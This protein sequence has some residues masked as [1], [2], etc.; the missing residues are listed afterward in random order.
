M[1]RIIIL[2]STLALMASC[3]STRQIQTA[4]TK[5]DTVAAS[6]ATPVPAKVDTTQLIKT[7]LQKLGANRVQ[8]QTFTAKIDVDY[9]G[10]DGKKYDL[11]ANIRMY[12]DSAIW[13]SA[14]ATLL[15]IEVMRA[16]ITKDSI[17]LLNK[18]DKLYTARSVNYLQEVTALPMDLTIL[19]NLLV[20]NPVFLD[21][22]N[23]VSYSATSNT[24]SLLSL[25]KVFKHLLTLGSGDGSLLHSKLD[26]AD[27]SRN[28]TADLTY[29]EYESKKGQ[30]FSTERRIIVAEKTRLDIKLNFKQYEFNV[31]VSFPFSVPKNYERN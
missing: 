18:P 15:G 12:K 10:G 9:R 17:K 3:R 28:R 24:V 5:K 29:N 6:V 26:D 31:P 13:V 25:G 4:I 22:N 19:Q 8:F 16:F 21:S 14:T 20:G 23:V 27:A 2:A 30:L 11:N 7:T 1:L